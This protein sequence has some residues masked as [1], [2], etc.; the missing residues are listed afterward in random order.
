MTEEEKEVVRAIY[1]KDVAYFFEWIG[2]SEELSQGNIVCSICGTTMTLDN[3][4]AVARKS[5]RLVFCCDK[6][7]CILEFV[8]YLKDDNK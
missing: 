1:H 6:D 2:L 7:S 4:R 5:G 8:S 3:F